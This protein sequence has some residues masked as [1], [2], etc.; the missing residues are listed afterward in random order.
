MARMDP[1]WEAVKICSTCFLVEEEPGEAQSK[2]RKSRLPK[3]VSKLHLR[4]YT[5]EIY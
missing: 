4:T 2:F 3:K 1:K 5:M